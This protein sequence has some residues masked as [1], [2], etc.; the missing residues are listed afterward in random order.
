MEI[1]DMMPSRF[2]SIEHSRKRNR[3]ANVFQP[4]DPADGALDAH[5][6]SRM[7]HGP[8]LAQIEI[9]LEGFAWEFV[10]LKAL[11]EQVVTRHALATADNFP[12]AF[13]CEDVHAQ[14]HLRA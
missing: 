3:L 5:T 11:N 13:R 7:R 10:F 8:V 9:P 2:E 1:L 4:A 12:V 14:R 6:K